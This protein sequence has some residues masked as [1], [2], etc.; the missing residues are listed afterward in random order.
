MA[1]GLGFPLYSTVTHA[2]SQALILPQQARESLQGVATTLT[3]LSFDSDPKAFP[4][5]LQLQPFNPSSPKA[6][7]S[8]RPH[9]V[10]VQPQVVS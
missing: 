10:K 1:F 7:L 8:C 3:R 2:L 9:L 5:Q 6:A 4:R